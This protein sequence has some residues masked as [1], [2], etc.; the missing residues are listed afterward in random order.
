V[1]GGIHGFPSDIWSVGLIGLEV[2]NEGKGEGR[3]GGRLRKS[4]GMLDLLWH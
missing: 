2:S 1:D 3:G 4:G